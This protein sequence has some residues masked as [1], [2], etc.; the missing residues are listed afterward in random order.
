MKVGCDEQGK[1][2][3]CVDAWVACG[4]EARETGDELNVGKWGSWCSRLH[5]REKGE[6]DVSGGRD[7]RKSVAGEDRP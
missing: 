4:S 1:R 6:I 7:V 5:P 2:N 3:G